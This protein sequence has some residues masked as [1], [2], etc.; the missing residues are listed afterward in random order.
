MEDMKNYKYMTDILNQYH[1][2]LSSW[3]VCNKM[4]SVYKKN[5]NISGSIKVV[6]YLV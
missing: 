4:F 1:I 5:I 2:L 6:L 3:L